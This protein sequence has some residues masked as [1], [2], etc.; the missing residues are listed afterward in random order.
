MY[1]RPGRTGLALL[2]GAACAA[3]AAFL[4]VY[5]A[6]VAAERPLQTWYLNRNH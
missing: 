5:G 6:L 4:L 3:S 1:A 2:G